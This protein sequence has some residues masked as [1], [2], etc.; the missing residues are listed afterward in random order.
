MEVVLV[1]LVEV[2]PEL[3]AHFLPEILLEVSDLAGVLD[4]QAHAVDDVAL[5]DLGVL[6]VL[7]EVGV[8][9]GEGLL[10]AGRGNDLHGV[11]LVGVGDHVVD[12]DGLSLVGAADLL[13]AGGHQQPGQEEQQVHHGPRGLLEDVGEI[14][15]DWAGG[16]VDEEGV[17]GQRLHHLLIPLLE[18]VDVL[19]RRLSDLSVVVEVETHDVA[20][21]LGH[22]EH[23]RDG[24]GANDAD[25]P[26]IVVLQ[27]QS[28]GDH[29]EIRVLLPYLLA[30]VD[31]ERVGILH[32]YLGHPIA[33]YL[34]I[35]NHL[36][37]EDLVVGVGGRVGPELLPVHLF[38]VDAVEFWPFEAV[39]EVDA[40]DVELGDDLHYLFE[41]QVPGLFLAV[42][43]RSGVVVADRAA[44]AAVVVHYPPLLVHVL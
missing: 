38:L 14:G 12:V 1:D 18:V 40:V 23:A 27:L 13:Q 41:Q 20:E 3:R 11:L 10:L 6:L 5:L 39:V 33:R 31:E 22:F 35:V 16:G 21:G 8:G 43:E 15:P 44:V 26:V 42:V 24:A 36:A 37:L 29:V 34:V 32:G 4:E 2:E 25:Q 30:E 7:E 9:P 19:G 17:P 28:L